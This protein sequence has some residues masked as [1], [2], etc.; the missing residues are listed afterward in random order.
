MKRALLAIVVAAGL[1]A[2]WPASFASPLAL[3]AQGRAVPRLIAV[4]D[5]HG[6][7]EGITGILRKAGLTDAAN[8][9]TGGQA[10]FMQTGDYMDRGGDVRAV[11][12]LLMALE[13][14]A[15]AAGGRAQSLLGNHEVMNLIGFTRDANAAV[16][17]KFAD[18]DSSKRRD[19]AWEDYQ[20]VVRATPGFPALAR[21]AFDEAHPPGYFE[22]REAIGPRGKYGA[23][24]RGKPMVAN[25]QRSIFM[26]AG[27]PPAGA[28]A[29]LDAFNEHIRDEVRRMDRFVERLVDKKLA[30]PFF[31]LTEVLQ[32]ASGQIRAADALVEEAKSTGGQVDRSRLDVDLLAEAGEILKVDTWLALNPGGALW[33]RGLS[34]DPDDPGG[35]PFASLLARYDAVRFVTGHTPTADRRIHVRFGGRVVLIDTGMNTAFYKGHASALEIDGNTL[36]AIYGDGREGLAP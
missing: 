25:V 21:D 27:I 3:L 6:S 28:P 19:R 35:G 15:K 30:L 10:I 14:E 11:L 8:K 23:W 33:W 17:E 26:H 36:S 2:S 18:T 32:V 13:G 24:L 16:Y 4:G 31:T 1:V 29:A 34:T 22:Y 9:W 12:D 7:L 20:K 5:I